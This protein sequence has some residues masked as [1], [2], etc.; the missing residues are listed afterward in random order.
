MESTGT[1]SRL[2]GKGKCGRN[3]GEFSICWSLLFQETNI[4]FP[5]LNVHCFVG[6]KKKKVFN[7]LQSVWNILSKCIFILLRWLVHVEYDTV[8]LLLTLFVSRV[9]SCH[10]KYRF[11]YCEWLMQRV[12]TVLIECFWN[13]FKLCMWNYLAVVSILWGPLRSYCW[14][15]SHSVACFYSANCA[16]PGIKGNVLSKWHGIG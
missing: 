13:I 5:S 10:V 14:K 7:C 2:R 11:W 16:L 1:R 3:A 9:E 15:S 6:L 12:K 4:F 8:L